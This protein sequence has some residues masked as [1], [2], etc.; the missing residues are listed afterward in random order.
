[1]KVIEKSLY[2][3]DGKVELRSV[4]GFSLSRNSFSYLPKRRNKQISLITCS[5][6]GDGF[7]INNYDEQRNAVSKMQR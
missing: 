1:M 7:L 3:S 2:I 6:T 5:A 4:K